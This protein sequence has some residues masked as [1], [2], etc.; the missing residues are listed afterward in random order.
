V[1]AEPGSNTTQAFLLEL[2]AE[3][4]AAP[5]APATVPS[6]QVVE[7]EE[8]EEEEAYHGD[9]IYYEGVD[10]GSDDDTDDEDDGGVSVQQGETTV[11]PSPAP[12]LSTAVAPEANRAEEIV[13]APTAE[14]TEQA[15]PQ[16]Q[17]PR[18]ESDARPLDRAELGAEEK[19]R[20]L[21]AMLASFNASHALQ[22]TGVGSDITTAVRASF[23]LPLGSLWNGG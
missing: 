7:E 5:A 20:A 14:Q 9:G 17:R 1:E 8:E 13:P 16:Q 22:V 10:M 4:E 18:T 11:L 3:G 15:R 12:S 6:C 19:E 21:A 23:S 2:A